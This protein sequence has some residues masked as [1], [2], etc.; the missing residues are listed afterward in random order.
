MGL[1]LG[2]GL[3]FWFMVSV[4]AGLLILGMP[5][6]GGQRST[7]KWDLPAAICCVISG[8]L[9]LL[10]KWTFGLTPTGPDSM[11][12]GF[13]QAAVAFSAAGGSVGFGLTAVAGGLL[14]ITA[15][16]SRRR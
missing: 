5:Q 2:F 13:K 14:M 16:L 11:T 7:R 1:L 6:S 8:F 10:A 12:Q 9:F 15:R 3:L 4:L